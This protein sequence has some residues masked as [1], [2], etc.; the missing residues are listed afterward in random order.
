MLC[1]HMA[2]SSRFC[3]DKTNECYYKVRHIY[4]IMT[5]LEPETNFH[6]MPDSNIPVLL[7]VKKV[8]LNNTPQHLIQML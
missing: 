2:N 1:H 5:N 8:Y 4:L 6:N 7:A 3:N